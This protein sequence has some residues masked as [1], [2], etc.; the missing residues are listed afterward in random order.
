MDRGVSLWMMGIYA[1]YHVCTIP[2][3]NKLAYGSPERHYPLR[4]YPFNLYL[5]LMVY[6]LPA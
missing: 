1:G 2:S 6:C 5:M 4:H 3:H